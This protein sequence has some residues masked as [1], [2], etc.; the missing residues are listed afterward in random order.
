M[1][2]LYNENYLLLTGSLSNSICLSKADLPFEM[3]AAV[4][5]SLGSALPGKPG[6]S[7]SVSMLF[8]NRCNRSSLGFLVHCL[9]VEYFL[10]PLGF[11][12]C[13]E[14]GLRLQAETVFWVLFVKLEKCGLGRMF[15]S[16]GDKKGFSTLVFSLL[17]A[18]IFAGKQ[19][20]NTVFILILILSFSNC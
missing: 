5:T 11:I 9:S 3:V 17:I 13:E 12:S 6:P 14:K 19:V 16:P 4:H 7:M 20:Q 2:G 8:V 15:D 1:L 18:G 10:S